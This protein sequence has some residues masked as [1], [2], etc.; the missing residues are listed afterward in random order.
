MLKLTVRVTFP[1]GWVFWVAICASA[2]SCLDSLSFEG[3]A[4]ENH[5]GNDVGAVRK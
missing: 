1:P 4:G 3:L 2:N 5:A